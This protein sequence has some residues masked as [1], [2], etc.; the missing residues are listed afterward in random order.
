MPDNKRFTTMD[1]YIAAFPEKTRAALETVRQS[2]HKA[3]PEATET[4]SYGMPT[5][6]L[7][8]KH[9]VFFAGWKQHLSLHPLPAGDAAFQQAIAPY[10]RA[11]GTL[12]LPLNQPIPSDLVEHLVTFLRLESLNQR[13]KGAEMKHVQSADGTT[14]AFDYRGQGPALILVDGALGYRALGFVEPLATALSPYFRVL[15]YDRRGRGEST[16]TQPFALEREIEDIEA[17][18]NEAGGEA[19]VCGI[20]SGAAL[21]LEAT[22]SLGKRVKKL[23]LYEPPYNDEEAAHLALR[24][25]QKQLANVLAEGRTGDALGLFML[26]VGMPPDHLEGARQLPLWPMWEAVAH[27]LPYDAAALGEDGSVP[28]EKAARIQVPT[29][30][31]D[32]SASFPFMHTT[33][34]TLAKALPNGEH[35]TLEGQTHEV[36]ADVLAPVLRAFFHANAEL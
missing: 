7:H 18:I 19:Y 20:S 5:F 1:D 16:D 3:V 32:G 29:L 35:R 4:M 14:I 24:N 31:M 12:R 22:L 23:A 26:L 17:L 11:K 21:A 8:G 33:A 25:Y 34:A 28:L 13:S 15:T 30:V 27:T 36:E 9:L 2:I 6:N 10:R